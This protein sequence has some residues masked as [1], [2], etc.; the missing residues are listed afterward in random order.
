MSHRKN[1]S[2]QLTNSG[3]STMIL[4]RNLRNHQFVDKDALGV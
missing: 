3:F 1:K 4:L 2:S